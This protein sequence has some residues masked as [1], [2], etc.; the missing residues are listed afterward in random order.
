MDLVTEGKKNCIQNVCTTSRHKYI[1]SYIVFI[2]LRLNIHYEIQYFKK[3]NCMDN[4]VYHIYFVGSQPGLFSWRA[5][6]ILR[7]CHP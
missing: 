2:N 6:Y 7:H 3:G 5:D 1:K 4:N